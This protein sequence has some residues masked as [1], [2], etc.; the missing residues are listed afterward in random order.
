MALAR[1][2]DAWRAEDA[3]GD[4]RGHPCREIG[5]LLSAA[6]PPLRPN[7]GWQV[8]ALT[9]IVNEGWRAHFG[10][11]ELG[12]RLFHAVGDLDDGEGVQRALRREVWAQ[13]ARIALREL[14]PAALGGADVDQTAKELSL[15]AEVALDVAMVEAGRAA[16]RRYGV[17]LRPSGLRSSA[18]VFG[19]G[20]LGGRELNAG[21]DVDLIALYDSDDGASEVTAH[22][23]WAY[24]VRRAVQTF[25]TPT[26]DGMIWRV[27][28]RLRPEGSR[29]PV[30]YSCHAAE[31]YYETFGRLWERAAM[32]RARPVAGDRALGE[33][34]QREV[35]LPFV[36]RRDV[37]PS[38]ATALARL[39]HQSRAELSED[40][41]RDL[42]LGPGGIREAEF[43]VQTLQLVWG[44]REPSL[45]VQGTR[46]ALGRLRAR[47]YVTDREV[48]S[49][50]YAYLLL[51]RV[52]HAI[53]WRTGIQTHLLP[54]SL[55][56]LGTLGR[57]LGFSG[58][59]DLLEAV[60]GARATVSELFASVLP[61]SPPTPSQHT[62]LLSKLADPGPD[63]A[64]HVEALF[65]SADLADH[66][67]ALARHPHDVLGERTREMYPDFGDDL[68]DALA[69]CADPEQ[70]ARYIRGI[71]S[72]FPSPGPYI[73]ALSHDPH[74]MQR[75]VTVLGASAFVGD[76]LLTHPEFVELLLFGA[77]VPGAELAR[78][79]VREEVEHGL[80]QIPEDAVPE[81][82]REAFI[83]ALRR[84]KGKVTL[85]VA[86][87]DLSGELSMRDTMRSL[88]D[89]A[90]ATLHRAVRWELGKTKGLAVIAMGKLGGREIGYGADLD[91]I[92][93]YDPDAAPDGVDAQEFF[94]RA[95]QRIVRLLTSP[96]QLGQ[97][98][99]LDTRLRPSGSQGL[100]V[101]SLASFAR[102][103]RVP[104]DGVTPHEG[105]AVLSSGAAWE[106][107]AL[108]RA[109]ACAGDLRL[110]RKVIEVAHVAA[111]EGGAASAEEV[112]HLRMRMERELGRER[113]GRH[114]LKTG[115]GGLL[116]VEFA[117]QWLQMCHGRDRSVR[118]TETQ[119]A[120]DALV[121]GGY[122]SRDA[123]QTFRAGYRFLRRLEQRIRVLHGTG[124][125]KLDEGLPGLT[126]LARR[127]GFERRAYAS[128][129][130]ALLTA[131]R[132]ATTRI[133]QAYLEVLGV[134]EG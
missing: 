87:A 100:L 108:L 89:L 41:A 17:L 65:D 72:R 97:G 5:A 132:D 36:Y 32:L 14:L 83:G 73:R 75:V 109:R 53:Q 103:H 54:S 78:H 16:E 7:L 3:F 115:R 34:F 116:D 42:K 66:L 44:G 82:R 33:S 104:L 122:L 91:V 1:T 95:A 38:I 47:G 6:F 119:R 105:P 112:H 68:L 27:D 67:A 111:Y 74:V 84:A 106:R 58:R 94:A 19:M 51:R 26:E 98:Y 125:S 4:L 63:L 24:V 46:A 102:Y 77:P 81:E 62:V 11:R 92:F 96:H 64:E 113:P 45:R 48:T 90:D 21:S 121:E 117:A 20:K 129:Q 86:V 59:E 120:L 88:S 118:S 8:A 10:R 126:H 23:H 99:E 28:L 43:F 57:I 110:G 85:H 61:E 124:S 13:K 22:E 50:T 130:G 37:D 56:E 80:R 101:T 60:A 18:V 12:G 40:P 70:A 31:R 30:V 29:G 131:Y 69:D 55:G 114:D 52:E 134:S 15:L 71:F 123:H 133:R 35:I 39:V 49:I 2:I 9:R 107:Q 128:E 76:A 79:T 93:I 25:D 127:M